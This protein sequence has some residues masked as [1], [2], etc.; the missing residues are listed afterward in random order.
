MSSTSCPCCQRCFSRVNAF[1][2]SV[3]AVPLSC[4]ATL[5]QPYQLTGTRHQTNCMD[6]AVFSAGSEALSSDLPVH[7]HRVH[8]KLSQSFWTRGSNWDGI[9]GLKEAMT[10]LTDANSVTDLFQSTPQA[11]PD[12]QIL[13]WRQLLR[14]IPP[15][16]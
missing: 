13:A 14:T 5:H 6:K 1:L 4:H 15:R 11:A 3:N 8:R 10:A 2:I 7:G 16:S 12:T 9:G